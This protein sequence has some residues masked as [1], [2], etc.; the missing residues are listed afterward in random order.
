M[1]TDLTNGRPFTLILKFSLPVIGG[2][3]FQLFYTLAD[4]IIVGQTI[5]EDSLAAVGST[6]I[7][8]YFILCFIQGFT[9][10]FSVVLAQAFGLKDKLGVKKSIVSSTYLSIFFTVVLTAIVLHL[11]SPM[12]SWMEIPNE[13]RNDA[14]IYLFIVL[15]GTGATIFYNMISNMLRA[16]GDSK[17]PLVFL[18]FSSILNIFLDLL[19]IMP[20]KM[21]VA[22][23]ALATVLSQFLASILCTF[24]AVKKYDEFNIEKSIWKLDFNNICKHLKIGFLMGFQLSVMCIGQIVMQKAV[25][26]L[27]TTAI[28][29]Y[30]V[31][32]KVDQLSVLVNNAFLVAI[33]T[34]VG[35][36]YGA[37]KFDRVRKGVRSSLIIVEG[38]NILIAL[39]IFL[40]EP[41]IVSLFVSNPTPDIYM[42]VKDYFIVVVPFYL[43]LGLIV[44]FRTTDQSMNISWAPFLACIL[45]LLARCIASIALGRVFGYKGIAF[46]HPLAWLSSN[47]V[48]IPVYLLYMR[49]NVGKLCKQ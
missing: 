27:G 43:L 49:R 25:N 29:G 12:M 14:C 39:I 48:T 40:V 47:I 45:E 21:G 37:G 11:C 13:I 42:Y 30:T 10:G 24:V 15:A 5:G 18:I 4:T 3:I 23:A 34:Y 19:F 26:L 7:I 22:G 16:L 36:N 38:T 8:V 44:V 32:T 20:L 6:T 35:Q 28:S 41:Y 9:N 1:T 31:A 2:N 33:S 17:T 46:A